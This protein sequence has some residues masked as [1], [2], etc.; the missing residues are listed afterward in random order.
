MGNRHYDPLTYI[1]MSNNFDKHQPT[2]ITTR[3]QIVK[4]I[5]I[6]HRSLDKRYNESLRRHW[7][8]Y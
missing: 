4:Y 7:I 5:A 2:K 3:W 1:F 6:G 8:G